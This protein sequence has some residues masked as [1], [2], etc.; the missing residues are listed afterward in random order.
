MASL[1]SVIGTIGGAA[2]TQVPFTT[3]GDLSGSNV[4]HQFATVTVPAGQT[5]LVAVHMTL[6]KMN[7]STLSGSFPWFEFGGVE[8]ESIGQNQSTPSA[9]GTLGPGTHAIGVRTKTTGGTYSIGGSGVVY[10][11]KL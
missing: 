3:P 7:T 2:V 9:A 10:A 4:F 1:G 6:T 11:V 5:W 8:K